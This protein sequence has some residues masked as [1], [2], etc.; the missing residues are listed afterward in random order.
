MGGS[1]I[2]AGIMSCSNQRQLDNEKPKTYTY[3]GDIYLGVDK[4]GKPQYALAV[5]QYFLPSG[6]QPFI[7]GMAF[8]AGKIGSIMESTEL[9]EDRTTDD[10]D[11]LIDAFTL[12]PLSACEERLPPI[13]CISGACGQK[14]SE[15]EFHFDISQYT[16]GETNVTAHILHYPLDNH[17]FSRLGV[18]R[19]GSLITVAGVMCGEALPF[20]ASDAVKHIPIEVRELSFVSGE[21]RGNHTIVKGKEPQWTPP[22]KKVHNHPPVVIEGNSGNQRSTS[23]I[24]TVSNQDYDANLTP[25]P[26]DAEDPSQHDPLPKRP[27][28]DADDN[29][30]REKRKRK[31]K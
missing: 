3:D 18:P 8:V 24:V 4:G 25:P 7:G 15:T 1:S 29:A 2:I 11:V 14:L 13:I 27:L 10:Y 28:E 19:P 21:S 16:A 30:E 26:E 17:R 23:T 6:E 20:T 22:A 9:G 12:K 5:I 31:K